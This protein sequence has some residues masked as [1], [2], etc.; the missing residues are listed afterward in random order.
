MR[1]FKFD[2]ARRRIACMAFSIGIVATLAPARVALAADP[3]DTL[4]T[5]YQPVIS[6]S[7]DASGFKHHGDGLA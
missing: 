6:E 2:H 4:V 5:S 3:I 7:V 1:A